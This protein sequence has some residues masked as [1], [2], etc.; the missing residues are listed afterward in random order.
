MSR[1][2]FLHEVAIVEE[3]LMQDLRNSGAL[4]LADRFRGTADILRAV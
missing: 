1:D 2:R 3:L 4:D